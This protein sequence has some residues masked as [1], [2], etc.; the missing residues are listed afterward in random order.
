MDLNQLLLLGSTVI[1]ACILANRIT[2]RFGI[3]MLLAFIGL[4]MAFGS[5]GLFRIPFD[6]FRFASDFCTV[7]L[8][9][10]MFYGGFGTRWKAARPIAGKAILLSSLGT[11]LTDVLT[12]IFC[13]LILGFRLMEGLL[14]G[15]VLSSTDAAS[16]FSVL[17]SQKLSLK[18]STDSLLEIESGSNDP[19]A[20]MLTLI[21]L[22]AMNGSASAGELPFQILTTAFF[23]VFFGLFCG[24]VIALAGRWFLDHFSFTINGFDA[25]FVLSIALLSYALPSA[26]GGNGY[27]SAYLVGI[28][29][30]NHSLRN[31]KGLVSFFDGLTSLMQMMIFF[32]LGLLSFPSKI[33]A[34][35][36]PSLAVAAF[37]TLVA[38]PAATALLLTPLKASLKQQMLISWAGLRG[39]A[40]IVFAIMAAM[41]G[42]S[43]EHDLFHMVFC[44]VL[45]SIS[46]QGTLLPWFA[47]KTDMLDETGNILTTFNDYTEETDVRFISIPIQKEHPWNRKLVSELNLPPGTLLV[48]LRRTGE[49]IVPNGKTMIQEGDVLVL[50]ASAYRDEDSIHLTETFV[51]RG[52]EWCGKTIRELSLPKNSLAILIRRGTE[53]IIPGGQTIIQEGDT[54][55]VNALR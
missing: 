27:L 29:L 32:I 30:G 33:A 26:I 6:N 51:S 23:Q 53:T 21:L 19:F 45:L 52:H 28:L 47:K 42:I 49:N 37:L 24:I 4:G 8:I 17:R 38:R 3:P 10:I 25:A 14:A 11:I 40:S 34:V 43:M 36:L 54:I 48:F 39:A 44:I 46:I 9:F 55:V 41:S 31:K 13:H 12:G 20:Y 50:G 15:A 5:E 18:Y 16:V 7:A 1:I 22:S 2:S 35:W